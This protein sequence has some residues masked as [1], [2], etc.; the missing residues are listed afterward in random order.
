[1]VFAAGD[2]GLGLDRAKVAT[3]GAVITVL[4]TA[5]LKGSADPRT[6]VKLLEPTLVGFHQQ[7]R[8]VLAAALAR[9]AAA[10]A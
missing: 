3:R 6:I 7:V 2:V 10:L 1:M 4:A 9:L 8:C 5:C